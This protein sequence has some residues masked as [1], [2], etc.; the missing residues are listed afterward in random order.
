MTTLAVLLT[1]ELLDPSSHLVYRAPRWLHSQASPDNGYLSKL[2]KAIPAALCGA[3]SLLFFMQSLL[4]LPSLP[5][6]VMLPVRSVTMLG[7]RVT[8]ANRL[9]D[10]RYIFPPTPDAGVR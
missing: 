4:H 5:T 10:D 8:L 9:I 7:S 2:L 1:R 6:L 3:V